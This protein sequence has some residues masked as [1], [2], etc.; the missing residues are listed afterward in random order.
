MNEKLQNWINWSLYDELVDCKINAPKQLLGIHEYEGGQVITAFRPDATAVQIKSKNGKLADD[1]E[2]IND[3]G[4]F[5]L[6][7]DK[8]KYTKYTYVVTYGDGTVIE[9]EDPYS[10]AS[11]I[12]EVDCY[13]FGE[14]K[15]YEIYEK[16]GAHPM[17]IDGVDGT[18]F[19]VW[20]PL[21]P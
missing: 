18:Y 17:T 12:S 20:A 3:R 19:A 21:L 5:A 4:F 9:I 10:F 6:Y 15:H 13:L 2:K 7:L 1:M 11:Q 14:G 16:L 8:E